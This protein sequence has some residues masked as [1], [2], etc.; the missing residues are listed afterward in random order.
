MLSDDTKISKFNQYR[1]CDKTPSIIYVDLGSLMKKVDECKS[2]PEKL[3]TSNVGEHIPCRILMLTIQT[4]DG[5]ENKN[6]IYS[7]EDCMKK[8]CES[9]RSTQ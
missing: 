8:I 1:K 6:D 9:L 2:N 3:Y 5:I 7:G 4:L